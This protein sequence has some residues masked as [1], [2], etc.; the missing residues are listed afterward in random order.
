MAPLIATMP[1]LPLIGD[2]TVEWVAIDPATGADVSG[3]TVTNPALYGI[4]L[5][6]NVGTVDIPP[7]LPPLLTALE[8][9]NLFAPEPSP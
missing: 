9:E 6:G 1:A 7:A 5:S 4:D 2:Y 3:V 8:A